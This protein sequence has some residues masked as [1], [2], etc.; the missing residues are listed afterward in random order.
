MKRCL[1]CTAP[2][3][4]LYKGKPLCDSHEPENPE[5]F[6]VVAIGPD[7]YAPTPEDDPPDEETPGRCSRCGATDADPEH[8]EPCLSGTEEDGE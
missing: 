7:A 5:L 1:Y 3:T 8:F 6:T 4:V 2:A